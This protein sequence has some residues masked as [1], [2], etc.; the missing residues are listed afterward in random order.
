[1][2]LVALDLSIR[3]CGWAMWSRGQERPAFGTWELAP[4]A[5]FASRAFVRLHKNLLDLHTI[6]PIE[7]MVFE[8]A[9]P[10][11]KLQGH[12]SAATIFGAAGLAAHAMSFAEAVGC[13]WRSVS[14]VAWRKHFLG[15]MP[16]GTKTPDLKAMAMRRCREL[17]FDVQKH[18]AAEACG[19]LDF[20]ISVAGIIAPWRE[21][22]LER[23]MTPATDG[24]AVAL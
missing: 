17:N 10:A 12:S 6:D 4:H 11:F 18:D 13:R 2:S 7:E 1:M 16:R 8:E 21:N 24:K 22:F 5:D 3:S 23:E 19:L 15:S 9:I 20:A 14:I